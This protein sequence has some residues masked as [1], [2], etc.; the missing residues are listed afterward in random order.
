MRLSYRIEE[1]RIAH[2]AGRYYVILRAVPGD[3]RCTDRQ[4]CLGPRLSETCVD[5]YSEYLAWQIDMT[6]PKRTEDARQYMQW[7]KEE[8]ERVRNGW[9][10]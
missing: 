7:L 6:A 8:Q 3:E 10:D 1:E 5:H 4:C 9:K 2:A